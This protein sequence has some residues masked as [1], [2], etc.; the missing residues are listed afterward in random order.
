MPSNFLEG[1]PSLTEIAGLIILRQEGSVNSGLISKIYKAK[2]YA[3]EPERVKFIKFEVSFRGDHDTYTVKFDQGKWHCDCRFFSVRGV[4]SHTMA[5]EKIL[6]P[7]LRGG[8]N[9]P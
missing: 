4:C 2:R 3:Q 6:G 5:L 1:R 9:E 8:E 7:M